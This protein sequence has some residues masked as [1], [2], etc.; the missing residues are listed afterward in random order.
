[1][2]LLAEQELEHDDAH[3]QR[4]QVGHDDRTDQ[5]QRRDDRSQ[6]QDQD[7]Q[8][9][10][11]GHDDDQ[12][13]VV[14]GVVVGVFEHGGQAHHR[15]GGV[16]QRGVRQGAPGG[17]GDRAD[18]VH[19]GAA[20]RVEAGLDQVPHRVPVGRD[21]RRGELFEFVDVQAAQQLSRP[22]W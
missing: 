19:R 5:V 16:G 11:D 2:Q 1:M 9:D 15:G 12:P 4:R 3:A 6:Q 14:I 17:G 21:E 10:A 20:E 22:G 13:D 7:E 18:L 8:H